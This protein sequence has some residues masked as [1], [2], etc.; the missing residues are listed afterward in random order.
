MYLGGS[1]KNPTNH[2]SVSFRHVLIVY[3]KESI[4]IPVILPFRK[5]RAAPILEK[6]RL[7]SNTHNA[8]VYLTQ[9]LLIQALAM[10]ARAQARASKIRRKAARY[11]IRATFA[12]WRGWRMESRSVGRVTQVYLCQNSITFQ[13]EPIR[14]FYQSNKHA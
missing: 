14:S 3:R 7:G 2:L 5:P 9:E 6:S 10:S 1:T 12:K 13:K 4:L 8:R 11:R